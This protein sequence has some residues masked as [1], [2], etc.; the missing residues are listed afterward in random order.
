[1]IRISISQPDWRG[2]L[3]STL[4]FNLRLVFCY[5]YACQSLSWLVFPSL[6]HFLKYESD[7]KKLT[8]RSRPVSLSFIFSE[9]SL[10]MH[11]AASTLITV[12]S[13]H[14]AFHP[15]STA[16]THRH[17]RT[18]ARR[19]QIHTKIQRCSVTHP[20]HSRHFQMRG[21]VLVQQATGHPVLQMN[22]LQCITLHMSVL[23]TG[24]MCV[25]A[26]VCVF[27]WLCADCACITL[28][29]LY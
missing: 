22:T 10:C 27:L 19:T 29:F 9:K 12:I 16:H 7:Y 3:K 6:Y 21:T 23:S 20:H 8:I 25:C 5:L 26:F 15:P 13:F 1:M 4:A 11:L 24:S 2:D 28:H 14:L 17:T 18:R